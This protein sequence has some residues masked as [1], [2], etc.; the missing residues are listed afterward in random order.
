MKYNID[1]IKRLLKT[2]TPSGHEYENEYEWF[3]PSDLI[4]HSAALKY[5]CK[6][7]YERGLLE[8]SEPGDRWGYTYRIKKEPK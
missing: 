1:D 8:R 6:K 3:F 2:C 5:A 4:S 7:L